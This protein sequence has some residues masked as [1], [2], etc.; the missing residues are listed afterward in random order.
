M[1][2]YVHRL[3]PSPASLETSRGASRS[4]GSN[5]SESSAARRRGL[6]AVTADDVGPEDTRVSPVPA[7]P[8]RPADPR[9]NSGVHARVHPELEPTLVDAR[10]LFDLTNAARG[11]ECP[12]Y[13]P[14]MAAA[15]LRAR[16]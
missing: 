3:S 13:D 4:A 10:L 11:L 2:R 8:A 5:P 7:R 6:R 15:A 9:R 1:T 16:L 12:S 14:T